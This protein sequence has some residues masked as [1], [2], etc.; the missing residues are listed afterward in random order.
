MSEEWTMHPQSKDA[1]QQDPQ[2]GIC[3]D[4]VE[5]IE[6]VLA[7]HRCILPERHSIV[8]NTRQVTALTS[9][10]KPGSRHFCSEETS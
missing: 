10:H 2:N 3:G 4:Q 6:V 8:S 1:P 7:S 9:R 5:G